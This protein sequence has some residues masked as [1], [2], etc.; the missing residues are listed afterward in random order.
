VG[1]P[2]LSLFLFKSMKG[3]IVEKNLRVED[4]LESLCPLGEL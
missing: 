2:S 1:K 4:L 3:F